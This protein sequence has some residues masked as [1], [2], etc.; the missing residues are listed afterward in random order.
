MRL[1]GSE[2]ELLLQPRTAAEGCE[3]GAQVDVRNRHCA[4]EGC[5]KAPSFNFPGVTPGAFCGS[6]KR[7]G[8]VDVKHKRAAEPAA[9]APGARGAAARLGR[10]RA[11]PP[12]VRAAC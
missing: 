2:G 1:V 6:H 8:M 7:E 11:Y 4:E 10:A 5:L 3:A 12:R 9:A